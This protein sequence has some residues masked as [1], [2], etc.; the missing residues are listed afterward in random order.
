MP[1][2]YPKEKLLNSSFPF[3]LG[4]LSLGLG[5]IQ[6]ESR[7]FAS[8]RCKFRLGYNNPNSGK[9][10]IPLQSMAKIMTYVS[11]NLKVLADLLETM[12]GNTV[13]PQ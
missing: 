5:L 4:T 7:F 9:M 2:L 6:G 12:P 1:L 3:L 10:E 8:I 11:G 13:I